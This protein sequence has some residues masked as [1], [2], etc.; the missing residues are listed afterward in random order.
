M[1][2]EIQVQKLTGKISIIKELMI[3]K[4]NSNN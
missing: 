4:L 2:M 1:G 3:F